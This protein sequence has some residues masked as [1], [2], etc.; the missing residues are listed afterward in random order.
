MKVTAHLTDT[1]ILRELG[2]R[3]AT[4]RLERNLTQAALAEQAGVSKRTL[5]RLESGEVATQ[6][7]GF[8]RVCRVLGLTERL[9][10]LVPEPVPSPL[11]QMKRQGRQRQ[12]AS[13]KR[14]AGTQGAA[15]GSGTWTWG[16]PE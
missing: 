13:G 14:A 3:L 11:A 5:E 7:S 10:L 8:V 9:D 1:A 6:L 12:R 15:D 2:A 16:E 4:T